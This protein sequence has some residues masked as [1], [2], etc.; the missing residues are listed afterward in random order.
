MV[1][2]IVCGLWCWIVRAKAHVFGGGR[3]MR[4]ATATRRMP[5]SFSSTMLSV[6]A[7]RHPGSIG[8]RRLLTVAF[9]DVGSVGCPLAG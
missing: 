7:C 9:A 2:G 8:V 1:A 5:C 3:A 6:Y 4:V